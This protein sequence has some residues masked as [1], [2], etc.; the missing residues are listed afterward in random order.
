M[1][2][3]MRK[4]NEKQ[5]QTNREIKE[6]HEQMSNMATQGWILST[7]GELLSITKH[8]KT[9]FPIPENIGL[10]HS[11]SMLLDKD[12][13]KRNSAGITC[14]EF[15]FDEENEG[16]DKENE[17]LGGSHNNCKYSKSDWFGHKTP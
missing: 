3:E 9:H 16:F 12:S 6:M 13:N 14:D 8:I 4:N 11:D 5:N 7:F 15:D 17:G 10:H 1:F 2:S